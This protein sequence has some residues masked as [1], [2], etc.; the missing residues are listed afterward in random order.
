MCPQKITGILFHFQVYEGRLPQVFICDAEL[1]RKICVKDAE[2]FNSKRLDFDFGDPL[3]NEMPDF[4]PC[5]I[6]FNL[7]RIYFY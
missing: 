3:M 1:I 4:L 6:T 2:Y 5:K 7:I